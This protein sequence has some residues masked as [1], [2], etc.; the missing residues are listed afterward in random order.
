MKPGL[1]SMKP[2]MS[3][4]RSRGGSAGNLHQLPSVGTTDG[5]QMCC[6][7]DEHTPN[8]TTM[9]SESSCVGAAP[10]NPSSFQLLHQN[11]QLLHT[12][13]TVFYHQQA[14]ISE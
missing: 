10:D 2:I 11:V 7:C 6:H 14:E 9:A 4:A 8:T 1:A 12:S 3:E 13:I 5:W